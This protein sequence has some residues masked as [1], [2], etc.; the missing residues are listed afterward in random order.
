M[1]G[2]DLEERLDRIRGDEFDQRRGEGVH[3]PFTT[4]SMSAV[5][6]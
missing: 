1:I 4:T 6:A 5:G 3:P 2:L